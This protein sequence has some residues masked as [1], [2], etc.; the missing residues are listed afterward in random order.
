MLIV[1]GH[2]NKLMDCMWKFPK[3][4]KKVSSGILPVNGLSPQMTMMDVNDARLVGVAEAPIVTADPLIGF[5]AHF[6]SR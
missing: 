6:L 3:R 5:V 1:V 2:V 4:H